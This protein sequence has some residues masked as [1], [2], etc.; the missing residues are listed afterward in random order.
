[1]HIIGA[2]GAAHV[3]DSRDWRCLSQ[4]GALPGAARDMYQP[5]VSSAV[6]RTGSRLCVRVATSIFWH[7]VSTEGQQ[8]TVPAA[9]RDARFFGWGQRWG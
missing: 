6:D 2:T 3:C 4:A 7:A 1:M 8:P 9:A 5:S